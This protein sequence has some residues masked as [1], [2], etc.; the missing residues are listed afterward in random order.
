MDENLV[1]VVLTDSY[2]TCLE[3]SETGVPYSS[4][5]LHCRTRGRLLIPVLVGL[6]SQE[7]PRL[8]AFSRNAWAAGRDS[9]DGSWNPTLE[10]ALSDLRVEDL[11]NKPNALILMQ[12]SFGT[13]ENWQWEDHPFSV[14]GVYVKIKGGGGEGS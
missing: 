6:V 7:L 3:W 4:R 12:P 8:F 9:W 2:G 14:Q 11:L 13:H 1:A 10:G 5:F